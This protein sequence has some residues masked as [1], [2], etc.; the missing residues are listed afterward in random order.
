MLNN[1][2]FSEQKQ[3]VAKHA[4]WRWAFKWE[5]EPGIYWVTAKVTE[6]ETGKPM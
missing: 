2:S 3:T 1:A 5:V 6:T 4:G